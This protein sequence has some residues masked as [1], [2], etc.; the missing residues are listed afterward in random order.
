M[1]GGLSLFT[2]EIEAACS[3][4][5]SAPKA[6]VLCERSG[7]WDYLVDERRLPADT[8]SASLHVL[9]WD[10]R[11]FES[12]SAREGEAASSGAA[13][14][15]KTS[16]LWEM[17]GGWHYVVDE[18]RLFAG[19]ASAP[20]TSDL[21]ERSGGWGY[22]VDERRLSAGATSAPT[23]SDL[24]ERSGGWGYLVDE[25]MPFGA[26]S[27]PTASVPWEISDG[28][29]HNLLI[30]GGCVLAR[31][32]HPMEDGR[33]FESSL[34]EKLR[35]PAVVRPLHL[36]PLSYGRGQVGEVI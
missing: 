19:A 16:V 25:R 11:W 5:A 36:K 18:R 2:G 8:A 12:F 7:G 6:S 9:F 13:S 14:A 33:W 20:T 10:D 22:L 29:G 1:T 4:A 30:K 31:P 27:A 34:L 35:L 32:L 23:T 28:W 15:P 21:W 26:A 3:G 17:S 24:W